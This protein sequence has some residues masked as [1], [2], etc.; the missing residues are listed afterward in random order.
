MGV[1]AHA[2]DELHGRP[3]GTSIPTGMLVALAALSI[4]AA[5]AIGIA[6]CFWISP[7][8]APF[9]AVGGLLV[10]AYNLELFGG[11]LHDDLWFGLAWGAFPVVTAYFAQTETVR[12]AAVV[13]GAFAFALSL[14]QRQLSTPV[15]FVRRSVR[16]VSGT[17]ELSTGA[18]EPVT[19]ATLLRPPETA[20]RLLSAAT[21]LLATALVL[22]RL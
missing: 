5:L 7:W 2:L 21:P 22:S 14:A 16:S 12:G 3:L 20:L 4:A 15:R 19:A 10:L 6:S 13:A 17:L 8:L 1:G 18:R 9:V 11:R